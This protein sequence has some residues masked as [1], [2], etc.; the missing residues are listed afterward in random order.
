MADLGK[1]SE[2]K[3][4]GFKV[5]AIDGGGVRGIIPAILLQGIQ[6]EL[7][8]PIWKYFDLICGTSS[9]GII[10][11]AL[12]AGKSLEDIVSL[13]DKKSSVLFPQPKWKIGHVER[14]R[15]MVCGDGGRFDGDRLADIL[16]SEFSRDDQ[17]LKMQD[18]LTRICVTAI[19]IT[20]GRVAVY[21]TPHS[22][23]YPT[24]KQLTA[25]SDKEMWN[26]AMATSAAPTFFK[27]VKILEAYCIDGGIW[28]N[29]PSMVGLTEAIRS[30]F[31]LEE[32][33]ILSLGTGA[34]VFQM[35][36]KTAKKM[37]LLN[38]KLGSR[39]VELAFEAQSQAIH[40]QL[41]GLLRDDRYLRIQHDFGKNIGLDDTS[42]LG[43]L[44]AAAHDLV[45]DHC[46]EIKTRFFNHFATN[47]YKQQG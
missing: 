28:A 4:K 23:L 45:R 15:K 38:W 9:G 11:L 7:N 40:N 37:N 31:P 10:A 8:E 24:E 25:D 5:L 17:P 42:R 27:T 39:L 33:S 22:V 44:K 26:I 30:G 21:K 41:R 46:H 36:E 19:N 12:S 16:R 47:S 29:N 13:Y 43:D 35:E 2:L 20:N 14:W 1:E 32:I 18:A 6:K 34:T 3:K